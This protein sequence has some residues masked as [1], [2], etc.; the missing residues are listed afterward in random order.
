MTTALAERLD[1][2]HAAAPVDWSATCRRDGTELSGH[3]WLNLSPALG[4][5]LEVA[6]AAY[7]ADRSFRR[8]RGTRRRHLRLSVPVRDEIWLRE[9]VKGKAVELLSWLSDDRW[10]LQTHEGRT[11]GWAESAIPL[12]DEADPPS[13]AL[14]FSGGL[15]SFAGAAV[16]IQRPMSG[17]VVLVGVA[18]NSRLRGTQKKT[19]ESLT[20]IAGRYVRPVSIRVEVRGR[21]ERERS[22]LTRGLLY[23]ASGAAVATA[24]GLRR[25]HVYE[26]GPGSLNLEISRAQS[27]VH[28]SRATHPLSLH[29]MGQLVSMLVGSRFEFE[30]PFFLL[31]KVEVCRGLP[32]EAFG[33]VQLT[34]S[35][36][37]AHGRRSPYPACGRCTSCIVRQHSLRVAG[38]TELEPATHYESSAWA[39]DE[40][41]LATLADLLAQAREI[42]LSLSHADAW[43]HLV[44]RFQDLQVLE[45]QLAMGPLDLLAVVDMLS[46]YSTEWTNGPCPLSSAYRD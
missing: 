46:R 2:D 20:R 31:T 40:A 29:L 23:L 10:E 18:K 27:L 32:K 13:S 5:L 34:R 26:N 33:M 22:E 12:F 24:A 37:A 30:N 7:T 45:H 28:R 39:G 44:S 35:C 41:A 1:G 25:L 43:R 4:D 3:H 21:V 36:D 14:L 42:R 8:E 16:E 11:L 38:L 19:G 17:D 15:D 6:V 9:D